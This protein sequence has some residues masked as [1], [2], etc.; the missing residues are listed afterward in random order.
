MCTARTVVYNLAVL[1][2]ISRIYFGYELFPFD[3]FGVNLF[4]LWPSNHSKCYHTE[5]AHGKLWLISCSEFAPYN[6]QE[7]SSPVGSPYCASIELK[8]NLY[9]QKTYKNWSTWFNVRKNP[10]RK[11]S[12]CNDLRKMYR[13]WLLQPN[14]ISQVSNLSNHFPVSCAE[15]VVNGSSSERMITLCYSNI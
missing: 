1:I 9:F 12:N 15:S 3:V 11:I 4:K 2:L 8:N 5:I 7:I 10:A 6:F 14:S 13:K